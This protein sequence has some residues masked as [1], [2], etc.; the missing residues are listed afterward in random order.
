MQ[1][2]LQ[3]LNEE[4]S[5]EVPTDLDQ[6]NEKS[7]AKKSSITFWSKF[8]EALKNCPTSSHGRMILKWNQA[9][10]DYDTNDVYYYKPP[11]LKLSDVSTQITEL[12][13]VASYNPNSISTSNLNKAI[14]VISTVIPVLVFITT[15]MTNT[16]Y[17]NCW[18]LPIYLMLS[19]VLMVI[20]KKTSKRYFYRKFG[21]RV[22]EIEVILTKWNDQKY[23][24]MNL[25]WKVG[26]LGAWLELLHPVNEFGVYANYTA[27]RGFYTDSDIYDSSIYTPT[28]TETRKNFDSWA[29]CVTPN[30]NLSTPNGNFCTSNS[31]S[32]SQ[33]DKTEEQIKKDF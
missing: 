30:G 2:G 20:M 17:M 14:V 12:H 25:I 10:Q 18:F 23:S 19:I 33:L 5:L 4:I 27:N 15:F 8:E 22:A 7:K 31:S 24:D 13:G 21:E 1:R 29:I 32:D 11:S 3:P 28:P 26:N 16:L 9:I 6:I